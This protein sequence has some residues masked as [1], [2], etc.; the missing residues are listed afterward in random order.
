MHSPIYP[1]LTFS[2]LLRNHESNPKMAMSEHMQK[3]VDET[4]ALSTRM[5]WMGEDQRPEA[6]AA[7]LSMAAEEL[8]KLKD[9]WA[10]E[11]EQGTI[12]LA[13]DRQ[14][15]DQAQSDLTR[16]TDKHREEKAL[17]C[18]TQSE[19]KATLE[20][21]QTQL[22]SDQ[23]ELVREKRKLEEATSKKQE[24]LDEE[25]RKARHERKQNQE[26]TAKKQQ[27]L[28]GGREQ[29][30]AERKDLEDDIAASREQL[31]TDRDSIGEQRTELEGERSRLNH[32][33]EQLEKR[34][35]EHDQNVASAKS[36]M[37]KFTDDHNAR[38]AT[39]NKER[40]VFEDDK[41]NWESE[42]ERQTQA[43]RGCAEKRKQEDEEHQQRLGAEKSAWDEQCRLAEEEKQ[44]QWDEKEAELEK[45]R[46]ELTRNQQSLEQDRQ[47]LIDQ[48]KVDKEQLDRDRQLQLDQ[49]KVDKEQLEE[50]RQL[51]VN[52][53][54]VDKEQLEQERQLQ[55]DQCKA[56]KEQL[57]RERQL[58]VDQCKVDKEQ[59]EEDRKAWRLE[60]EEWH[61]TREKQMVETLQRI[62]GESHA[63]LKEMV[64]N[65]VGKLAAAEHASQESMRLANEALS[66]S[67][68]DIS[69]KVG[70]SFSSTEGLGRQVKDSTQRI[71]E[72]LTELRLRGE[73]ERELEAGRV[74][75]TESS[76]R[77][78]EMEGLLAATNRTVSELESELRHVKAASGVGKRS[79]GS[80]ELS[81]LPGL[82]QSPGPKGSKGSKRPSVS[83][84]SQTNSPQPSKR[85]RQDVGTRPVDVMGVEWNRLMN[86]VKLLAD[87]LRP[88]EIAGLTTTQEHIFQVVVRSLV[89]PSVQGM[90]TG[91]LQQPRTRIWYCFEQLT[92]HGPQFTGAMIDESG[93]PPG[94]CATHPDQPCLQV[95]RASEAEQRRGGGTVVWRGV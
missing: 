56:D 32:E 27:Q 37:E 65:E 31:E 24:E 12:R 74:R 63:L 2:N 57:E 38:V 86:N 8:T 81:G 76:G 73:L 6:A 46:Q 89:V 71:E 3:L 66:S 69:R 41:K 79:S 33:R 83:G 16:D 58:H 54:K 42:C 51:H 90:V 50:E 17:F 47:L 14:Q 59:L 28:E 9:R 4:Q 30:R 78:A 91:F 61:A 21:Q 49:C 92:V 85:A 82:S 13:H 1:I 94:H 68:A 62:G 77:I 25:K 60:K 84:P 87:R 72:V 10:S 7:F 70:G 43:Q 29:L 75:A 20:A 22:S 44:R 88:L 64:A 36:Y 34:K 26:D 95:R 39:L 55:I 45:G 53:C 80:S 23:S 18:R 52:Q 19:E 93:G 11:L 15:L 40:D 5:S 67:M 48:C 35:R